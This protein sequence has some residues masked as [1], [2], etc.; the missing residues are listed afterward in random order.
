MRQSLDAVVRSRGGAFAVAL[1]R[2]LGFVRIPKEFYRGPAYYKGNHTSVV[3]PEVDIPWPSFPETK[4]DYELELGLVI[5]RSG[6]DIAESD[7]LAYVFGYTIYNDLSA[8]DRLHTELMGGKLG[9]LKGKD[10]EGGNAIGPWIVTA[11]E[12]PDPGALRMEV[13]VNG[14]SRGV[15]H[16]SEMYHSVGAMVAEASLGELVLPG[17]FIGTGAVGDGTGIERWEF[18]EP[19]DVVELEIEKIGLLRNRVGTCT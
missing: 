13:R 15:G 11:D 12:I 3:G 6:Q 19:G 14:V 5:G 2:L 8:R 7:A 18:L 17:E 9:P 16:T 1:N 4:L 10:F